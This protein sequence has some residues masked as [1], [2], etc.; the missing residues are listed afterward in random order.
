MNIYLNLFRCTVIAAVVLGSFAANASAP[1]E[2]KVPAPLTSSEVT[3]KWSP[4]KRYTVI[5]KVKGSNASDCV[6]TKTV[7]GSSVNNILNSC[8]R[9]LGRDLAVDEYNVVKAK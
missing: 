1:M 6:G 8:E 3:G 4:E 2:K 5:F 7:Q 9:R